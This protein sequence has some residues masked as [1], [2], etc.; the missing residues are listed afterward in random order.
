MPAK[1]LKQEL[2][3]TLKALAPELDCHGHLALGLAMAVTMK[4]LAYALACSC[5]RTMLYSTG[6]P[7]TVKVSQA[8]K[9]TTSLQTAALSPHLHIGHAEWLLHTVLR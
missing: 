6:L 9:R 5:L 7:K 2:H 8:G 3:A 1:A 4:A